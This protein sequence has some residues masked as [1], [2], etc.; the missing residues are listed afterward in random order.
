MHVFIILSMC[1]EDVLIGSLDRI[2]K[3]YLSIFKRVVSF[4]YSVFKKIN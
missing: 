4:K 2:G 1:M 3:T